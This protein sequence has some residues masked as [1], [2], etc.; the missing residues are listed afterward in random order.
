MVTTNAFALPNWAIRLLGVVAPTVAETLNA[1]S[2]VPVPAATTRKAGAA[3]VEGLVFSNQPSAL[4][5]PLVRSP[6]KRTEALIGS[7]PLRL[8]ARR[9]V[10]PP[11]SPA[12]VP[13]TWLLKLVKAATPAKLFEAA[14]V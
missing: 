2:G 9:F 3:A 5:Q 6:L 7:A 13:A 8:A 1:P 4:A 11:P 14:K 12:N 10:K